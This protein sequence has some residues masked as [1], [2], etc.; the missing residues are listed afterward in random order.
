MKEKFLKAKNIDDLLEIES[1]VIGKYRNDFYN[2]ILEDKEIVNHLCK[3]FK[4]K[5]EKVLQNILVINGAPPTDD[6]DG[7]EM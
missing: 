4:I 7:E 2:K 1:E 6:F 3:I 5:D